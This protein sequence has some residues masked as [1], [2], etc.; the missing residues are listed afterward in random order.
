[1][2]WPINGKKIK[3]IAP[4][5]YA[6]DE[7]NADLRAANTKYYLAIFAVLL[8]ELFFFRKMISNDLLFGDIGDG[9]LCNL[10]AEHWYRFFL[11][12]EAFT[13]LG[14]FYP[15]EGILGY[16]DCLLGF[17][18]PYSFLRL[19][20][21]DTYFANKIV[22]ICFHLFGSIMLLHFLHKNLNLNVMSSLI[23]VV[24]FSL[25]NSYQ[26]LSNHTQLYAISLVPGFLIVIFKFLVNIK[27]P[28]KRRLYGIASVLYFEYMLYTSYYPI[29]FLV[30]FLIVF[31]TTTVIIFWRQ[32]INLVH[33]ALTFVNNNWAE[34]FGYIAMGVIF[35]I[36][37]ILIYLPVMGTFG[38]RTWGEVVSTLPTITGLINVS[39][40][41]L[42]Y[43]NL[44][45]ESPPSE[46]TCGFPLI[47]FAIFIFAEIY[48]Y[49]RYNRDI[50]VDRS[51]NQL[52][53]NIKQI[54]LYTSLALTV[55]FILL[56]LIK[57]REKSLWYVVYRFVPGAG[58][59]RAVSRYL[60]FLC[61]PIGILIA[62][63]FNYISTIVHRKNIYCLIT[64]LVLTVLIF[65]NTSKYFPLGWD[66]ASREEFIN[67][68]P[69][70]PE[71]CKVFYLCPD[72]KDSLPWV[73]QLDA[74]EIANQFDLKTIN[75]YS[76]Q[77]PIGWQCFDVHSEEYIYN[78][79]SWCA[80]NNISSVYSYDEASKNW[81]IHKV[82]DYINQ[83][84]YT[85]ESDKI[86]FTNAEETESGLVIHPEGYTYGPYIQM[87]PG[88]WT[89]TIYGENLNCADIGMHYD[90]GNIP[91]DCET[92]YSS[93]SKIE[94]EFTILE[95]I[96]DYE[97]LIK[98]S[99]AA[100]EEITFDY[101]EIKSM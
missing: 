66:R 31:C 20:G 68:V 80:E 62:E 89:A 85:H 94:L 67:N 99:D 64:V 73:Y 5:S 17:G 23:G 71:D 13:D 7:I 9:R 91:I 2:G 21:I 75:G 93:N 16:T 59:I 84:I 60:H 81:A 39:N 22:I 11:G 24:V 29:F 58:P 82:G 52:K 50:G 101:F 19:L 92:T 69:S 3:S 15:A 87:E 95:E 51:K 78:I 65:D 70:P 96:D 76:G 10:L 42:L 86:F 33:M 40:T 44:F 25:S 46:T 34:I 98:N 97:V 28:H 12:K 63:L 41:S 26:M 14:I 100:Q 49:K 45:K 88:E 27:T 90:Q 6:T 55:S 53:N 37:F 8:L 79:D 77:Y 36:P 74:W 54:Y 48:L 57:D 30:L 56:L 32:K 61:L 47:T 72:E 43:G 83:R 4:D 35:A 1:M 38:S 18:V